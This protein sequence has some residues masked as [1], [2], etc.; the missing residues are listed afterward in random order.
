MYTHMHIIVSRLHGPVA[1]VPASLPA[2]FL[3]VI[4]IVQVR[5]KECKNKFNYSYQ[6]QDNSVHKFSFSDHTMDVL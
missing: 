1:H 5:N 6:L 4:Y 2:M 3:Y